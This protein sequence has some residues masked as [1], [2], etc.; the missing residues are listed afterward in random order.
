M[1]FLNSKVGR[2]LAI[3]AILLVGFGAGALVF[4][5][6]GPSGQQATASK[7]LYNV[8]DAPPSDS[9]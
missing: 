2:A 6:R 7:E 8:L 1:K 3:L 9:G 4:R 5:H